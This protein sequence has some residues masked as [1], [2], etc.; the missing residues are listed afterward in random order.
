M[1]NAALH[2][3]KAVVIV[4]EK[5]SKFRFSIPPSLVGEACGGFSKDKI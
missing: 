4:S 2:G 5:P 1:F 3:G